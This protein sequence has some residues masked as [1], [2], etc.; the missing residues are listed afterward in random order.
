MNRTLNN[1]SNSNKN[2]NLP[3][4][5]NGKDNFRILLYAILLPIALSVANKMCAVFNDSHF[6]VFIIYFLVTCLFTS[7]VLD[8]FKLSKNK[9]IRILQVL[10]LLNM[11]SSVLYSIFYYIDDKFDLF[12]NL[13]GDDDKN[14]SNKIDKTKV[15]AAA[16]AAT[17]TAGMKYG[18]SPGQKIVLT[19]VLT[20]IVA[21]ATSAALNAVEAFEDQEK[22]KD[23]VN[24]AIKDHPYSDPKPDR[25][26]SPYQ[27]F[28]A[29]SP[30]E[31]G[32]IL[33]P[34][35]RLL[36]A[37]FSLES[38]AILTLLLIIVLFTY[39]YVYKYT[40]EIFHKFVIKYIPTK[41][42]PLYTI[43]IKNLEK[44]NTNVRNITIMIFIIILFL[45]HLM[46]IYIC[47][48]LK[49]NTDE[50]VQVYNYLKSINKSSILLI[51][52][53]R[54]PCYRTSTYSSITLMFMRNTTPYLIIGYLAC[55]AGAEPHQFLSVIYST[56]VKGKLSQ[57]NGLFVGL[58]NLLNTT[59]CGKLLYSEMNTHSTKPNGV[60]MSSTWGQSAWIIIISVL[61]CCKIIFLEIKYLFVT[62]LSQMSLKELFKLNNPSE[63]KRSAF[64]SGN[65]KNSTEFNEWLVGVTDGDG[66]FYF[67]KNKKGV[68]GFTFK[69]GQS[70]YNLRLLYYI[71][72]VLKVGSIS[73]PNYKDNTA[74]YRIRDIQHIIQ[75]I[76]PIFDNYPLLTRKHYLYSLFKEAILIMSNPSLSKE[77][78]DKLIS[79]I[80]TKSLN[81]IPT[82][83]VSPA[84][85]GKTVNSIQ[86][87][88][89]VISKYWLIGFTEAEGSFY[90]L[91]KGPQQLVHAFEIIS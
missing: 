48:K 65:L 57:I 42:I 54:Y 19:T 26:P 43:F 77:M 11:V 73:V 16:A 32:E 30:L 53:Y 84:W 31:E 87:A 74:E 34:L 90:I 20:P 79:E 14:S 6:I 45:I 21:G 33:S 81:G 27:S 76:L 29:N 23:A 28:T 58:L 78:K 89:K 17:A 69:I 68:W 88:K 59:R 38:L 36:D 47:Y 41:F 49:T 40:S 3:E 7:F 56:L 70:N 64:Y 2:N 18:G 61:M 72:S 10:L 35:E 4:N 12:N 37:L 15:V 39:G 8:G 55:A 67:N 75:Y 44:Y 82:D 80:K 25:V 83:Y 63:T 1:I 62:L 86:D 46:C 13:I 50:F 9:I 85:P 24:E 91:K 66:T 22:I 71:K 5:N 51:M 52:N 60:K